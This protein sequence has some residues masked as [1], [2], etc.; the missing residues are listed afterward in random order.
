MDQHDDIFN[1]EEANH[2]LSARERAQLVNHYDSSTACEWI[3][4]NSWIPNYQFRKINHFY[5]LSTVA[6]S[7]V[8]LSEDSF[9]QLT[10]VAITRELFD[11]MSKKFIILQDSNVNSFIG[12][13]KLWSIPHYRHPTHF[14]LVSTRRCNFSC[15]Y[16]HVDVA[17]ANDNKK[18]ND[19]DISIGEAI[20][21]FAFLSK[22]CTISFEF[23]GG[24]SLL[25]TEV[26]NKL[27]I[28]INRLAKKKRKK[29]YISIQTNGSLL[30][31]E[32]SD[33]YRR[34]RVSIG[35]SLDGVEEINDKVRV[36]N[37]GTGTFRVVNKK[38]K[39]FKLALLPTITKLNLFSWQEIIDLQLAEGC[40]I[41]AFQKVYPIN[42]ARQNW[43]KIGVDQNLFLET[44]DL[45]FE[46]LKSS[47]CDGHYPV[48]R[49]TYLALAKLFTDRDTDYADFGSPCGMIHSQL[50]FNYNGD[51][52]TCDE[53]RDFSEFKVGNVK[54]TPYDTVLA[55]TKSRYL[56]SMSIPNDPE[57]LTCAYRP[58]CSSCPVYIRATN[59]ELKAQFAGSDGCKFT[60]YI[61]DKVVTLLENEPEMMTK[62]LIYHDLR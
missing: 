42:S 4:R 60:K 2:Q 21:N 15:L 47:W 44:Y 17:K 18:E 62:V 43:E 8:A 39:K 29:V 10:G 48:E 16:C 13:Y 59:G 27:I 7:W 11:S 19:L 3:F 1:D 22:Q 34:H 38:A 55:G 58:F 31:D 32:L 14:I 40:K 30:T 54:E 37:K 50:L 36:T 61:Y 41:V 9:K 56:K 6:G 57:C 25:N 5:F 49:R 53:G 35:S 51:I 45:V 52:Y 20:V 33:F 23:Q 28:K 12:A 46:Y 24:E 26:I